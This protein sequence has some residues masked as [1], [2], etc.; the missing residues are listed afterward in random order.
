LKKILFRADAYPAIG[1][2]DL[3]SLVQFARHP[4]ME[5]DR[6]EPHFMVRR[7]PAALDLLAGQ[8]IEPACI[9]PTELTPAEDIAAVAAYTEKHQI[10][11]VMLEITGYRLCEADLSG[12]SAV[13]CAVD[14]YNWIPRG[15]DMVVNW[16]TAT[17]GLYQQTDHPGTRFFLGP[18]Y[19]FLAPVFWEGRPS[20]KYSTSA[21]PNVLIAMG[22]ADENNITA[23][24]LESLIANTSLPVRFTVI[25]G[26]GYTRTDDLIDLKKRT[27]ADLTI[28]RNIANMHAEYIQADYAFGAGGLTAYE[29]VASQTPCGLIACYPHQVHR[30]RY[31]ANAGWAHYLGTPEALEPIRIAGTPANGKRFASRLEEVIIALSRLIAD[32]AGRSGRRAA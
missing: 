4:A 25:V 29:M 19:V 14:F 2:G 12:I 8:G 27:G 24:V 10:D 7:H 17:E 1:T 31:F 21:V 22:G 6:Y 9:L 20:A 23:K 3:M 16:D 32:G 30:C 26:A 11:A 13:T 28:K 5:A 18:E 15:I